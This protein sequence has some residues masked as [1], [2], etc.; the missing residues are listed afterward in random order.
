[1]R[2]NGDPDQPDP[3][4]D[5]H[6]GIDIAIPGTTAGSLSNAVHNGTAPCNEYLAAASA[7]LR[8]GARDLAPPNQDALVRYAECMRANGVPKYP[9]PGTGRTSNLSGIDTNSQFFVRANSLCG[10]RIHAPSW[11]TNG[12]GPPGD[13]SVRSGPIC[14]NSVC[15]PKSGAN[16]PR[17]GASGANPPTA[18]G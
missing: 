17:T 1:M 8:A 13:V 12:W 10:H 18:G 9:D 7:A 4:I 3:T 11:W 14:G 6:G 5:A 2:S 16:R 15:T